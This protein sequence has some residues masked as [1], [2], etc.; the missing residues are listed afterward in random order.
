[1]AEIIDRRVTARI[2]GD[3]VG[4]RRCPASLQVMVLGSIPD[5]AH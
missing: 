4:A 3:F 1:M 5:L 2:D